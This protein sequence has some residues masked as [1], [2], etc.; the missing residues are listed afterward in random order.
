M[1]F[2]KD[3]PRPDSQSGPGVQINNQEALLI[4]AKHEATFA[5]TEP[6]SINPATPS[7]SER[8]VVLEVES[9]EE[10][11][12]SLPKVGFYLIAGLSPSEAQLILTV[13]RGSA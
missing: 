9:G 10:V 11:S 8:N 6:P 7:Y 2:A 12:P 3:G 4:V 5:G 1:W 13:H